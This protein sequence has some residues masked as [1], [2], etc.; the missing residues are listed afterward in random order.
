MRTLPHGVAA[1]IRAGIAE[2]LDGLDAAATA[3]RI[4]RLGDPQ[5]IAREAQDEVPVSP[6]VVV[7]PPVAAASAPRPPAASTRGF[8]IA[9][10]LTLSFGGFVVPFAGWVVGA[11]LVCFSTLWRSGE[12]AVAILVPLVTATISI[13]V[14]SSFTV[15]TTVEESG[16]GVAGG[17]NPLMPVW[18][19]ILWSG[20]LLIGILLVPASGL[21]LLWRLRGRTER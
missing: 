1:D 16:E 9:A 2:E 20:A 18:Y 14:W 15:I 21:W 10:A 17:A 13:L 4:A 5:D 7:A 3:E 11:V 8:A 6:M 12:K 19:D